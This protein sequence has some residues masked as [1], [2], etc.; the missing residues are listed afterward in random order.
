MVVL[1]PRRRTMRRRGTFR[2]A[3]F[4]AALVAL[5]ATA[6][7]CARGGGAG[8]GEP[9]PGPA[10]R[11]DPIYDVMISFPDAVVTIGG[12]EHT[13]ITV[14]L[15]A[16]FD[17]ETVRDADPR[18]RAPVRVIGVTAGGIAQ[19]FAVPQPIVMQGS[20]DG[21]AFATD[22]FG[23]IQFGTANLV[24]SLTGAI[25]SPPRRIAGTAE[26]L[27]TT[28]TGPFTAVRRR[29]YLVAGT[30]LSSPIGQAAVV[31]RHD[32]QPLD[33]PHDV[34]AEVADDATLQGR[35][36]GKRGRAVHVQERLDRREDALVERDARRQLAHDFNLAVAGD[37]RGR[38]VAAHEREAAPAFTVLDGFEEEALAVTDQLRVGGHRCFEVGEELGP[39]RD[40]RVVGGQPAELVEAELRCDHAGALAPNARKKHERAPVWHAP[41]PSCSTTNNNVSPSQ[42]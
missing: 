1:M 26:I 31:G 10:G 36:V 4:L 24:L 35:K 3:A 18:F 16:T 32:R 38:G 5:A 17:D 27:G 19:S 37:E 41:R 2:A 23:P 42:S 14:D 39:H 11:L 12:L 34:V 21:P 29:R 25:E 20:I 40:D 6:P 22:L 13:G 9:L 28:T 8:N 30:D 33:L 15:E 7:G